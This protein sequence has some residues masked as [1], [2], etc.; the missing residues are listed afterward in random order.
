AME[1]DFRAVQETPQLLRMRRYV[2]VNSA[3]ARRVCD[4]SHSEEQ[5]LA[6]MTD[7]W[8]ATQI[9]ESV[10]VPGAGAVVGIL[11]SLSGAA[12]DARPQEVKLPVVQERIDAAI[13]QALAPAHRE[14]FQRER[15][16]RVCFRKQSLAA[17][18][19]NVLDYR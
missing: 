8:I 1:L 10:E 3:L 11:R 17:L 6:L 13:A 19:V 7:A 18:L 2:R 9:R 16:A 14:A 4:L 12:V 15:D 5:A